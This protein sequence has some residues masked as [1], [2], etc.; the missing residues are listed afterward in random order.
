MPCVRFIVCTCIL[1]Q[2][3]SC[4]RVFW[5][6]ACHTPIMHTSQTS[7]EGAKS[8][9]RELQRRG[10]PHVVIAMAANKCDKEGM[11]K[12]EEA[13]S[14]ARGCIVELLSLGHANLPSQTAAT[15]PTWFSPNCVFSL[16]AFDRTVSSMR[17]KTTLFTWQLQPNRVTMSR[18]CSWKSVCRMFDV[19]YSRFVLHI[20]LFLWTL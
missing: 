13:V 3:L 7:F 9:V 4:A 20:Q 12:V 16:R 10:D 6:N 15:L 8:W 18:N 19:Q 5:Y 11:R 17:R 14:Y 1:M 2:R